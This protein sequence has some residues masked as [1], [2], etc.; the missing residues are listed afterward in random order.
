MSV[1]RWLPSRGTAGGRV[2]YLFCRARAVLFARVRAVRVRVAAVVALAARHVVRALALLRLRVE[3]FP[4]GA[5]KLLRRLA[6]I[7]DNVRSAIVGMRV[8]GVIL[9]QTLR[10]KHFDVGRTEKAVD[11]FREAVVFTAL[12]SLATQRISIHALPNR[13]IE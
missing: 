6:V 13:N 10:P 9:H 8:N 3:H 2:F 7:A 5:A 11:A 4:F 1:T 12:S